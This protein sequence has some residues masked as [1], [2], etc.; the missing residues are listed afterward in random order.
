MFI[1][2]G[3]AKRRATQTS[4]RDTRNTAM[5][6][7]HGR[8][9]VALCFLIAVAIGL[10]SSGC[11]R[12]EE[13]RFVRTT[14]VTILPSGLWPLQ[15]GQGFYE[16]WLGVPS[17]DPPAG[18][19]PWMVPQDYM[20]VAAFRIDGQAEVRNLDG[21]IKTG[22]LLPQDLDRSRVARAILT[23]QPSSDVGGPHDIG[24]VVA[25]G[26]FTAT[27]GT[28]TTT[29]TWDD[30]D[31]IDKDLGELEGSC[32]LATPTFTGGEAQ[33]QGVWF[34]G[35]KADDPSQPTLQLGSALP[36]TRTYEMWVYRSDFPN[37]PTLFPDRIFSC[38]RF[39]DPSGADSD[40][41]GP[42]A[43][44]AGSGPAYPGQDFIVHPDALDLTDGAWRVMVTLEETNDPAPDVPS[45][46]ALLTLQIPRM[47]ASDIAYQLSNGAANESLP[48]VW[49]QVRR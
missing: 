16:V 3:G 33:P 44:P 41:A 12:E 5:V 29:A 8:G 4:L 9:F 14:G 24:F 22:F 15:A 17:Q 31:V 10:T 13:D 2:P 1:E 42:H 48:Q 25:A 43:H 45:P 47:A 19:D 18:T 35:P 39:L 34:Y 28:I 36:A 32:L 40:G 21:E 7:R 30:P 49:I 20:P 23:Y 6:F 11:R 26:S 38:G 46:L 37:T 27:G